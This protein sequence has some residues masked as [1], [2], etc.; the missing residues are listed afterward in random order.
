VIKLEL[1]PNWP[2]CAGKGSSQGVAPSE[3]VPLPYHKFTQGD[4]VL[5]APSNQTT[6]EVQAALCCA[7]LMV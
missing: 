5:L 6:N 3:P 2:G 7:C 4:S 1:K